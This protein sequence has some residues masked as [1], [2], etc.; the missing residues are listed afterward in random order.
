MQFSVKKAAT[1]LAV[2]GVLGLGTL[3]GGVA[4]A[5]AAEVG[6]VCNLAYGADVYERLDGPGWSYHLETGAGFR[7]EG[8]WSSGGLNYYSGHGN[9]Q[10]SGILERSAINQATCHF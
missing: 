2:G 1:S 7:I 10:A 5:Q 3:F 6:Q 4:P 8:F 9:G